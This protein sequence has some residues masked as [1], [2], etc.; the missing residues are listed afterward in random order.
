MSDD[1][2]AERVIVAGGGIGGLAAALA[3][4]G[5]GFSVLVLEQA[6]RFGE[7]GAGIQMGPNAFHAL[8]RL[9]VGAA[10][11]DGA[12][13]IDGL[14]LMDAMSDAQICRIP[15]DEPFRRRYG[16]PY[17]VIHRA[18]LHAA[19]LRACEARPGISL[20]V[21]SRLADYRQDED[22]IAVQLESGEMLPARLLVGADGLRSAV[23][24]RVVGDGEPQVSGHTTYRSV[25]AT[26][27]MPEELRWNAATLWAGPKFHIVHY[28]LQGWKVFNLAV[29]VHD[30]A[31][32]PVAGEPVPAAQ[33]QA[34]F[35]AAVPR[36]RG[37]IAAADDW[38][39]WVLCDREP[40]EAWHDGR[41]VLLGDAAH[42]MLQYMAQG[43]CMALED[44]VC[45]AD[46]LRVSGLA[47]P[48]EALEAYRAQRL[49][50]TARVQVSSRA[51]GEYVYHPTGARRLMRNAAL[52]AKSAEDFYASL[53]WL[54]RPGDISA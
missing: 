6:A 25:I 41:A 53:D 42:P 18:D 46:R 15:L 13:F 31:D 54:Y 28:P 40:Q 29:T 1:G 10:A 50:R 48:A 9:G 27:R 12:V 2:T 43:A 26:E 32:Q 35:A 30:D 3:L 45:L 7:I 38:K 22:G 44:A 5:Q 33:V 34:A 20:R 49:P 51:M 14:V 52:A 24:R 37:I 4:S 8:D 21:S 19:L 16:N 36:A 47:R 39:R 17:A 11:Q 23:R